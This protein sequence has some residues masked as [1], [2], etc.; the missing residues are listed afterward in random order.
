MKKIGI[1]LPLIL[2]ALILSSANL[3]A[4]DD[5]L[6]GIIDA[7]GKQAGMNDLM[8]QFVNGI[9]PSAFTSGKSG[10]NDVLKMLSGI[11]ASDY[12]QYAALAGTLAGSLKGS[13]FLP[14]WANKKD[15]VLDQITKA[16]SI[17]EVAN[18]VLGLSNMIS[19]SSFTS[20]FKK[21]KGSWTD[22][23]SLLSLVK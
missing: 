14:D 7:V 15:G 8:G 2:F 19:P 9:K 3:K 10:K 16:A 18:G 5:Q 4:Q 20:S 1:F 17:A 13:S 11:N 21:K 22:A 12:T 6:K 23:L